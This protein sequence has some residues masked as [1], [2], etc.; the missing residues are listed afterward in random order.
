MK[1]IC[2]KWKYIHA[3]GPDHNN[4]I[5]SHWLKRKATQIMITRYEI[6]GAIDKL[7][8]DGNFEKH[9]SIVKEHFIQKEKKLDTEER[10]YTD[11]PIQDWEMMTAMK[12]I[13]DNW[14]KIL[15]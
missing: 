3:N 7:C 10:Q 14:K 13:C 11:L 9:V 4:R 5:D 2:L 6:M 15:D 8:I 1:R 12:N